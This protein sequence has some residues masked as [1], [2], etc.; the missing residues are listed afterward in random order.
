MTI[1]YHLSYLGHEGTFTPRVPAN[2][3]KGIEEETILRVCVSTTIEGCLS[4]LPRG[5]MTFAQAN[6]ERRGYYQVFKID[7]EKLGIR[8]DF[9]IHSNTLYQNDWV[10]DAESTGECW[11]T[12]PFTVSIEDTFFMKLNSWKE[13]RN[14]VFAYMDR[15]LENIESKND[16]LF[17]V[18]RIT[19]MIYQSE[20]ANSGEIINL[21]F[22]QME[23]RERVL[24]YIQ[25]YLVVE[26]LSDNGKSE[27][28]FRL[29]RAEN[30]R[31]LYVFHMISVEKL[32][33]DEYGDWSSVYDLTDEEE[34][35][36]DENFAKII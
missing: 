32:L 24:P 10:R 36:R 26:V 27:L 28:S 19:E 18:I 25:K 1:F 14:N 33:I 2:R 9:I 6:M 31:L 29:I 22:D 5:K 16:K 3:I 8:D 35:K 21:Q 4:A 15:D 17:A 7:T 11:I 30:L 13:E 12:T 23:E 34:A 20:H